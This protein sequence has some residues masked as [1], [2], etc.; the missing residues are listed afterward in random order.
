MSLRNWRI[1][2]AVATCLGCPAAA[3]TAQP[4]SGDAAPFHSEWLV[5][6]GIGTDARSTSGRQVAFQSVEWGR[7]LSGEH[8]PGVLKGQL[9]MVIEVT[10][11][12]VAFQSGHAEGAGFAPVMFRWNFR[13]HRAIEPFVDAAAGMVVTNRDVPEN[14]TRMN[15]SEHFGVGAR[16]RV[17]ERWAVVAGYRLH[18]VSNNGTAARNPGVTSHVGYAGVSWMITQ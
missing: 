8:G 3:A 14:T 9:E 2:V 4:S 13:P 18:H 15:F 6:G 10:P 12:F 16:F 1:V 11:V 17:A 7:N 5:L